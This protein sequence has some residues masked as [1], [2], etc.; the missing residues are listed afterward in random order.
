MMDKTKPK[1]LL[2]IRPKAVTRLSNVLGDEF[3][4]VFC[5]TV[6]DALGKLD[7]D[8]D[9]IICGTNFDES[10]MFELLRRV[11]D[12]R[13]T[14]DL[15]VICMKVFGGVLHEGSYAGV[16]KAVELLQASAY[17]DFTRWRL[18]LGKAQAAEQLRVLIRGLTCKT[19]PSPG[20]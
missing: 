11:K 14:R 3:S 6:D 8:I 4:L 1:L 15:P 2:A 17:V 10:R 20:M 18:E 12:N 19:S 16:E 5:H 13:A 7:E 9:A